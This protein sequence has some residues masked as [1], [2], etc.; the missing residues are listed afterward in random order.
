MSHEGSKGL[1]LIE[2]R[3]AMLRQRYNQRFEISIND[4]IDNHGAVAGTKVSVWIPMD[5]V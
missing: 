3:M 2:E 5:I 1:K 4:V